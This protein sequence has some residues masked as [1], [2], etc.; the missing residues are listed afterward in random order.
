MEILTT[1][2]NKDRCPHC[3]VMLDAAT[4]ASPDTR[5]QPGS[6]TIC[7]ECL[8]LLAF[9]SDLK[10]RPLTEAENRQ[11]KGMIEIQRGLAILRELHATRKAKAARLN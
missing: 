10:L 7:C 8:Q 1:E 4:G 2:L 9:D 3:G 5:P 11:A 6:F